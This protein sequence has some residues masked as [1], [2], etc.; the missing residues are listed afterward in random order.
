MTTHITVRPY[1]HPTSEGMQLLHW[2]VITSTAERDCIQFRPTQI[3]AN[4]LAEQ[5][6]NGAAA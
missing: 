4:A 1:F 6:Q 2:E 5:L 3:A